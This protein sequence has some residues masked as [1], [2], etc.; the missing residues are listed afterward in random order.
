MFGPEF[1]LGSYSIDAVLHIRNYLHIIIRCSFL[2]FKLQ[3]WNRN[4]VNM[5]LAWWLVKLWLVRMMEY[6]TAGFHLKISQRYVKFFLKRCKMGIE[7][8]IFACICINMS[9]SIV[10]AISLLCPEGQS[11]RCLRGSAGQGDHLPHHLLVQKVVTEWLVKESQSCVYINI[12]LNLWLGTVNAGM[13]LIFW[14][15]PK[16][17]TKHYSYIKMKVYDSL[18]Y[19]TNNKAPFFLE[20]CN[21]NRRYLYM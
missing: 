7:Y 1:L 12:F 6:C 9:R 4:N 19:K 18:Q 3:H 2:F 10:R 11:A 5:S 15:T 8:K 20:S 14:Y 17:H 13:L 16:K 21:S